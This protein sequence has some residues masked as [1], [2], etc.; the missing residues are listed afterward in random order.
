MTHPE[1]RKSNDTAK[2]NKEIVNSAKEP[3]VI[4]ED[5]IDLDDND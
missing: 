4:P 5:V 2:T 1:S 3:E